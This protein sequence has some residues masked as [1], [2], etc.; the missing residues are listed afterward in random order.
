MEGIIMETLPR[1][2]SPGEFFSFLPSPA[3]PRPPARL[4]RHGI[5]AAAAAAAAAVCRSLRRNN[6]D[7]NNKN[8]GQLHQ[9]RPCDSQ[10][11]GD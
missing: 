4:L 8:I 2:P 3:H 1:P 9:I 10:S 7:V 11:L 5:A 6:D